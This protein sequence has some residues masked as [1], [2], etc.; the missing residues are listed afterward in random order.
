MNITRNETKEKELLDNIKTSLTRGDDRTNEIHVSDL[1]NPLK[2]YMSKKFPKDITEDEVGYFFSGNSFENLYSQHGF[3]EEIIHKRFGKWEDIN[4]EI[5][6]FCSDVNYPIETKSSRLG[7]RYGN[8][9]KEIKPALVDD[10]SDQELSIMFEDYIRQVSMYMA[11]ENSNKSFIHVFFLNLTISY[12]KN[13]AFGKKKPRFRCYELTMEDHELEYT[14]KIMVVKKVKL[15]QSL[16]E[17]NPNN[18]D[19]C[20]EWMCAGCKWAHNPCPTAFN[21]EN[22]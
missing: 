13:I 14:R 10:L 5:D 16:M 12:D 9:D 22:L 20:P 21:S 18:L 17:N 8:K 7:W 19:K 15:Q 3:E 2:A 11:I 6:F 4:Y 1:C